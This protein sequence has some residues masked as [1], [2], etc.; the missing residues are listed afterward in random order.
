MGKRNQ[1]ILCRISDGL[2]DA[3]NKIRGLYG[4]AR[5]MDTGYKRVHFDE[6][7]NLVV[8]EIDRSQF[9]GLPDGLFET[10]LARDILLAHSNCQRVDFIEAG[11]NFYFYFW[12]RPEPAAGVLESSELVCV[13]R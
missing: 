7:F 4:G 11:G 8:V 1:H 2:R 3:I 13:V 9:H 12:I 6:K 5:R 10:R